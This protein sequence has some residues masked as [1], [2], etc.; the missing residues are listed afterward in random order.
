VANRFGGTHA[1]LYAWV[2]RRAFGARLHPNLIYAAIGLFDDAL[3]PKPEA[4]PASAVFPDSEQMVMKDGWADNLTGVWITGKGAG[5]TPSRYRTYSHGD[6]TSFVFYSDGQFLA[7]DAGY[8]HWHGRDGYAPEFHNLLLIDGQGPSGETLGALEDAVMSPH[9]DAATVTTAY[10]G[11]RV[12]RVFLFAEKRVLLVADFLAGEGEHEYTFQL[13]SPVTAGKA[14]AAVASDRV[15]WPGFDVRGDKVSATTLTTH[16]AGPVT[17]API[18]SH[19]RPTDEV[20]VDNVAIGAKWRGSGATALLSAL[21]AHQPGQS[22]VHVQSRRTGNLQRTEARTAD[23]LITAQV[24]AAPVALKDA[25]AEVTA[26]LLVT[27][28]E[29]RGGKVG[30]PRWIYLWD[31]NRLKLRGL[32]TKAGTLIHRGLILWDG[33]GWTVAPKAEGT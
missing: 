14:E 32:E 26:R 13:H 18:P 1:P 23:W 10:A 33:K 30:A 22:P 25:G 9:L 29:I 8:P 3:P 7:V 4:F 17:V 24:S 6:V 28:R 21:S 12:Q 2:A 19:W 15:S 11:H 27:G 20:P 5:W 16:F 31:A